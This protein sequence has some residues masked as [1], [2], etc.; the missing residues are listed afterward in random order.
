VDCHARLTTATWVT[1]TD[2][3]FAFKRAEV[4]REMAI[5]VPRDK[6]EIQRNILAK[7]SNKLLNQFANKRSAKSKINV[8]DV[9]IAP[10]DIL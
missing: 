3:S 7:L 8:P 6:G 10:A 2:G 1:T 5:Q 9:A 4:E